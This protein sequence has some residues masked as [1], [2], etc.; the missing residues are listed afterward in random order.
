[1]RLITKMP[2]L[3]PPA[4]KPL[5]SLP[6]NINPPP[7][8]HPK[9]HPTIPSTRPPPLHHRP[10]QLRAHHN[11]PHSLSL[12][13]VQSVQPVGQ[14]LEDAVVGAAVAGLEDES[15]VGVEHEL[16]FALD[17]RAGHGQ[18]EARGE[19]EGGPDGC[20]V[21]VDCA[22]VCGGKGWLVEVEGKEVD[23]VV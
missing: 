16:C 8:L 2:I 4:L 15:V 23:V 19:L 20:V 3:P 5:L 14:V 9:I 17:L 13:I 6:I 7:N 22:V 1:M 21:H 18:V 12:I 11:L 10:R